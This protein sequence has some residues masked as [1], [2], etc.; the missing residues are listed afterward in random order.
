MGY[1]SDHKIYK[2]PPQ[3]GDVTRPKPEAAVP[4]TIRKTTRK[5]RAWTGAAMSH[6]LLYC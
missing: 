3:D 1:A 4:V 5:S 2:A 6:A